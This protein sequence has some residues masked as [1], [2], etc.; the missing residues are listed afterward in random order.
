MNKFTSVLSKSNLKQ[1]KVAVTLLSESVQIDGT[2]T[3]TERTLSLAKEKA[4]ETIAKNTN[5]S[6]VG[7]EVVKDAEEATK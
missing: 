1:Y 3:V 2:F 7:I 5:M 4:M 6:L